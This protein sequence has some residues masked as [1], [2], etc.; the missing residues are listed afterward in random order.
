M[1]LHFVGLKNNKMFLL[2][3][4]SDT[5]ND[6]AMILEECCRIDPNYC[7]E[8]VPEKVVFSMQLADESDDAA[9]AEVDETVRIFQEMFGEDDVRWATAVQRTLPMTES[10]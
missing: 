2:V 10:E 8:N 3:A 7:Q 9:K 1:L 4:E 5:T 6:H